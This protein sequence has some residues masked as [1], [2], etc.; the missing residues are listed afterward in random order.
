MTQFICLA[1]EISEKGREFRVVGEDGPFYLM[2]F[3]CE[4]QLSA[5]HNVCPHQNRSLNWAPDKFLLS[6]DGLLVCA[7]HGATFNLD[8][9]VCVQGPCVGSR[10]IKADISVRDD[11]VWLA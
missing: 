8:S 4:N 5:Y 11:K 1:N 6:D 7:H 9:G 3:R 10:L 2:I